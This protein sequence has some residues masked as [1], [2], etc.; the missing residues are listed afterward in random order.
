MILMGCVC[1]MDSCFAGEEN[2][3]EMRRRVI[4][5]LFAIYRFYTDNWM[6]LDEDIPGLLVENT[7]LEERQV[8]AGWLHNALS[9]NKTEGSAGLR[10]KL[11][12][13]FLAAL[14]LD[15]QSC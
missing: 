9:Q 6:D 2:N 14:W 4:R 10:R 1:G 7:T 11:I 5:V 8:I 13:A 12:N 3:P 15:R